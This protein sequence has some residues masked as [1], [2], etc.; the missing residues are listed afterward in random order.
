MRFYLDKQ[1]SYNET[2]S[3]IHVGKNDGVTLTQENKS[4]EREDLLSIFDQDLVKKLVP[5]IEEIPAGSFVEIK[6]PSPDFVQAMSE[7]EEINKALDEVMG[8][9]QEENSKK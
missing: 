5:G 1:V 9:L 4:T 2:Y 8:C 6:N 3:I 7:L